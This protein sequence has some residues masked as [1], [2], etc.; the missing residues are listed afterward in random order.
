[1]WTLMVLVARPRA[2]KMPVSAKGKV[3]RER[4]VKLVVPAK[5]EMINI[6]VPVPSCFH[7][8]GILPLPFKL[9]KP[10]SVDIGTFLE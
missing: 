9:S 4:V 3:A 6:P 8:L 2:Q 5:M 1:M 7:M 10:M